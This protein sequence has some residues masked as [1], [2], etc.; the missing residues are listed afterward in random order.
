VDN[1]RALKVEMSRALDEVLPPAPWLEAAVQA[2]LRRRRDK[3]KSQPRQAMWRP[4]GAM[5]LAAGALII[6][7]ATAVGAAFLGLRYHNPLSTPADALSISAYQTIVGEDVNRVDSSLDQ[8]S[9]V[10]LQSV[11]PAP[12]TPVLNALYRWSDDLSL[13]TPP[14]RFA[15]IDVQV[16]YHVKTAIDDLNAV[17]ASYRARNQTAFDNSGAEFQR[18][19]GWLDAVSRSVIYSKQESANA[20]IATIQAQKQTLAACTE[21]VSLASTSQT[22]CTLALMQSAIC[23]GDVAFAKSAIQD[24]LAA[25]VRYAAPDSMAAQ[26]ALLQ[27]DLAVADSGVMRMAGAQLTGDQASFAEGHLQFEQFWSA[28]NADIASILGG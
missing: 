21:C 3:G 20:H 17:F 7:L 16:R 14:A 10:T 5:E 28:V 12:G 8:S 1:E 27:R 22:D 2:D 25:V 19:L 18:Q 26:D 24:V 11:C 4:R 9:C 6:V 23:E 13:S 15:V